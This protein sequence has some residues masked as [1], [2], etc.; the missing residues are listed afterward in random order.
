[1]LHAVRV[2]ERSKG[3]GEKGEPGGED[4]G[5]RGGRGRGDVHHNKKKKQPR[6]YSS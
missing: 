2:E 1:M 5:E 3:T 4:G 6:L